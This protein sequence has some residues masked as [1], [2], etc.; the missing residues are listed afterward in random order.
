MGVIGT[1]LRADSILPD[2]TTIAA[3]I[4]G[5]ECGSTTT[6][7][8]FFLL[9]VASDSEMSGCGTIGARVTFTVNGAPAAES[10]MWG[11]DNVFTPLELT[12]AG[13]AR[14]TGRVVRPV[15]I[16]ACPPLDGRACNGEE[17][18]LWRFDLRAWLARGL[19]SAEEIAAA[20]LKFRAERGETFG[21]MMLET[22]LRQEPYTF[23]SAV[24]YAP[25]A[26]EPEPYV[27]IVNVGTE[28]SLGG[29]T[30][31][32]ERSELG[33]DPIARYTFPSGFVLP[34]GTCRIYLGSRGN[35]T[36]NTCPDAFFGG[37]ATELATSAF[38]YV[39]LTDDTGLQIDVVS[40]EQ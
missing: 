16:Q 4:N 17:Q 29:W 36:G 20:W 24:Q 9:S 11:L 6:D 13:G 10:V 39:I 30:L 2:G 15:L 28:R 3:L 21:K 8:G 26:D 19:S 1:A 35:P 27:M 33:A 31:T 14:S 18:A 37:E 5:R 25:S 23:L 22:F 34:I 32:T 38:G 40:W 12:V 7:F